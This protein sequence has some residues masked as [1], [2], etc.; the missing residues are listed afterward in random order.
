M[1]IVD[2]FLAGTLD[3]SYTPALF[4]GHFGNGQKLGEGALKAHLSLFLKGGADIRG[5][6]LRSYPRFL[7]KP[8]E[9]VRVLSEDR[10]AVF[11]VVLLRIII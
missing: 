10:V 3:A 5:C 6:S 9:Q 8:S 2:R 1:Q 7:D 4:F 11:L